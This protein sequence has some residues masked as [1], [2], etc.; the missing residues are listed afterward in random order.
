MFG[1]ENYLGFVIACIALNITPGAD[2]LY[3]LT[4]SVS[5]GKTAGIYSVLGISTGGVVHTLL[6]SFGLSL[7]LAKSVLTFTI[8]KYL[9]VSYLGYLGIKMLLDKNRLFETNSSEIESSNRIRIFRQGLFTNVSNPK[10][11]LFFLSFLPQFINPVHT[12]GP[13]SFAILGLTF[14]TTGTIWCMFLAI[15][16]S[17]ITSSLRKNEKIGL[18]MQKLCGIVFIGFGLKILLNL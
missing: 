2:T 11:I 8:I 13:L 5:Q 15:A 1:I 17:R 16:A 10:V 3:I 7:I 12:K 6:I 9:G 14:V 4:R 18:I